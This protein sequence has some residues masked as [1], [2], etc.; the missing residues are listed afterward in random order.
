M[1]WRGQKEPNQAVDKIENVVG[2]SCTVHGDLAAEGAFRV[3]GTIEGSVESKG[4]VV[5]GESGTVKGNIRAVDVL[6]AGKIHGNVACT[7]HLDIMSTGTI[8]GD[9]DAK[10]LRV[11]TGGVFA[12]TSRMGGK[13]K[14]QKDSKEQKEQ[15]EQRDKKGA[16]DLSPQFS[17]AR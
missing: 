3:D 14:D 12:G 17:A 2:R 16:P 7:G 4:S 6:V 9:I 15:K 8:E 10:S 13:S 11:E 5:V 1:S